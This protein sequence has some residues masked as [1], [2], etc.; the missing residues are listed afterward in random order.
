VPK[1]QK[2]GT[3]R[4]GRK[5]TAARAAKTMT[6]ATPAPFCWKVWV[7]GI[8]PKDATTLTVMLQALSS[9]LVEADHFI[10]HLRL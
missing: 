10:H 7:V 8:L 1:Q 9:L 6:V 2:R 5:L 3:N 4:E